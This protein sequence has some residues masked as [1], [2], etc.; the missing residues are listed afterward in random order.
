VARL[1]CSFCEAMTGSLSVAGTALLSTEFAIV[2]C[3][4]VGRSSMYSRYNNDPRTLPWG[5]PS[6]TE[7]CLL[8][9]WDLRTRKY[10]VGRD[11]CTLYRNAVY[12]ILL[13]A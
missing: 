6:L 7:E 9:K 12:H 2:D 10:F 8:C 3:C 5:T 11:S 13:N 4:V 1:V